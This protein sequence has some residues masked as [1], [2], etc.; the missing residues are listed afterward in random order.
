MLRSLIFGFA[1]LTPAAAFPQAFMPHP[2]DCRASLRE[3]ELVAPGIGWA[4][5]EEP[6]AQ[7]SKESDCTSPH[8]LWTDTN[9]ETWQEITPAHMPVRDDLAVFFLDQSHG[10]VLSREWLEPEGEPRSYLLSTDDAGKSW[11]SVTLRWPT[12]WEHEYMRPL[13]VFF[14][15]RLH[16]W[17][18][19][20]W[21]TMHSYRQALLTT[22]DGGST[23][24]PL[25]EPPGAGQLQF[26]S[27][28]QGWMIGG[29]EEP[30]GI[31]VPQA[32]NL[33]ATQDGG[34][35]WRV[36]KVPLPPVAVPD[37]F[38]RDPYFTTF[39]FSD[40]G[41]G[42]VVAERQISGYEFQVFTCATEDGGK[43]WG[44]SS[45][46]VYHASPSFA[47]HQII[48]SLSDWPDRGL[49]L[50]SGEH[51]TS[52]A[53][54]GGVPL[55]GRLRDV[56]FFDDSNGWSTYDHDE[57]SDLV[58]TTDGGQTFAIISPE[59]VARAPLPPPAIA[60]VNGRS[61]FM[62]GGPS[63]RIPPYVPAG[64]LLFLIGSGF[65]ADNTVRIGSRTVQV[66]GDSG[67]GLRFYVPVDMTPGTFRLTVENNR[68]TSNSVQVEVRPPVPLQIREIRGTSQRQ[69]EEQKFHR[70]Q[71][72]WIRG[73]GFLKD[74]TV[75]FETQSVPV[76][77]PEGY[78]I[79]HLVVPPTL[80]PGD[81]GVYIT[82]GA[83]KSNVIT[84]HIE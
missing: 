52:P 80:S 14:C 18:V 45:F 54:A 9:G 20:Q 58:A 60:A 79:L 21:H 38:I 68:G 16:G 50:R 59:V 57:R 1:L 17:I 62:F 84:V 30:D 39:R 13:Q 4:I 43:T 72:I 56:K 19:W 11:R 35:H 66:P 55:H 69:T 29:P 75:W 8:L 5:V 33:W 49:S 70:G 15:D 31:P 3:A 28:Q 48:W 71:K 81:Y 78:N 42:L 76:S 7:P 67:R 27:P 82:N 74:N 22:E 24:K 47:G 41:H 34:L 23:W 2:R 61:T 83:G 64:G 40:S 46:E 26:I 10:W 53:L 65:L 51:I 44:I 6:V 12:F 63:S 77:R 32:E 37:P 25:P 36:V 73:T